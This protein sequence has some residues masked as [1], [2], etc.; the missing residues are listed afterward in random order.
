[1]DIKN[2]DIYNAEEEEKEDTAQRVV[3]GIRY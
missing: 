2:R 1:M 3:E